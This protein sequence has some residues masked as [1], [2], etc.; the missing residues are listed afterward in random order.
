[1]LLREG[2]RSPAP[3]RDIDDAGLPMNDAGDYRA[4]AE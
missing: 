3:D 2:A 1:M 4:A